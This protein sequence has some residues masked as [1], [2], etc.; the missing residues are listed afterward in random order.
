MSERKGMARLAKV[1]QLEPTSQAAEA[2]RTVRTAVHFGSPDVQIKTLV[3][4]S[5]AQGDGKS[6]L[7]SN[8]GVAMASAGQEVLILDADFRK[9][10]Q[11]K[12]FEV[13]E[14]APGVTD[15][16]AGGT[17]AAEAIQP[18]GIECL[19]LLPCGKIPPNPSEM[20]NSQAFAR[21][22]AELSQRYHRV[23]VD[24]PPVLALADA[25]I[26][27][28]TCDAVLLVLHAERSRRRPSQR[29]VESLLGVGT[30]ILGV[31]VNAVAARGQG[32]GYYEYGYHYS[33]KYYGR[34]LE[35]RTED[36]GGHG[37]AAKANAA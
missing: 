27:G 9:P 19:H 11:H 28:A 10:A 17:S 14:D 20:L 21:L 36:E 29:A 24:A 34:Q 35:G 8:L 12:I 1:V 37:D 18:T 33:Y 26:L 32:Y 30:R 22:L 4:T 5:P 15:V 25:R 16:L 7:V 23:L 13:D 31:V 2:F 6:T 3:V